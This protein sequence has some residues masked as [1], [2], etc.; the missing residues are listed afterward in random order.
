MCTFKVIIPREN[1]RG[2]NITWRKVI[3]ARGLTIGSAANWIKNENKPK[4]GRR[5]TE[6]RRFDPR[7]NLNGSSECEK[8]CETAGIVE[9]TTLHLIK[10]H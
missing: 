8:L 7:T 4:M 2:K 1:N 9:K 3:Y 5:A 6:S 10:I